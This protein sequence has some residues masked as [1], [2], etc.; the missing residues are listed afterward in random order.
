MFAEPFKKDIIAKNCKPF[1]RIK[2]HSA[3]LQLH[4]GRVQNTFKECE[5]VLNFLS[6][7]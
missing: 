4:T 7:F 2:F 6:Y 3:P 5:Y 1:N